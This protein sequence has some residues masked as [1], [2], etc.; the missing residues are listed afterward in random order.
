MKIKDFSEQIKRKKRE[1]KSDFNIIKDSLGNDNRDHAQKA[2]ER[3]YVYLFVSN[4]KIYYG[5]MCFSSKNEDKDE[6][7][8]YVSHVTSFSP[9]VSIKA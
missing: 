4:P 2:S 6:M 1:E 9:V 8:L 3:T 5:F 7:I